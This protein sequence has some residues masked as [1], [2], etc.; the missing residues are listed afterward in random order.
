[1]DGYP[2]WKGAA[3]GGL[4]LEVEDRVQPELNQNRNKVNL[5]P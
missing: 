4:D 2:E 5:Q 1:M 3:L